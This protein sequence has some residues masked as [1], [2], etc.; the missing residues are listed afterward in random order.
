VDLHLTYRLYPSKVTQGEL[1]FDSK[2]FQST[3]IP[4]GAEITFPPLQK[5]FQGMIDPEMKVL[6]YSE[7]NSRQMR[8]STED[9]TLIRKKMGFSFGKLVATNPSVL[10]QEA[11]RKIRSSFDIWQKAYEDRMELE[12]STSLHPKDIKKFQKLLFTYLFFVDMIMTIIPKPAENAAV[13]KTEAFKKSLNCFAEYESKVKKSGREGPLGKR[14]ST[15][16]SM[17]RYVGYWISS[18]EYY[19]RLK[20]TDHEGITRPWQGFFNLLLAVS[21]ETLSVERAKIFGIPYPLRVRTL[22][23]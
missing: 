6:L 12:I 20:I 3:Q 7:K 1:V 16:A 10:A 13:S 22:L 4:P 19:Q 5:L 2:I 18:E 8:L 14:G 21:Q 23:D 15:M 11:F 9:W 17:W